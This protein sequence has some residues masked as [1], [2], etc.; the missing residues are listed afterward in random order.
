MNKFDVI[1]LD[2]TNIMGEA[3]T[4]ELP[5]FIKRKITEELTTAYPG[6]KTDESFSTTLINATEL[7]GNKI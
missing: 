3:G 1:Y 6:L 7:T 2:I 5:S 4:E